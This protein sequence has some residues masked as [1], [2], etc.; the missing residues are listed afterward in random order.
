MCIRDRIK[1]DKI[2]QH[3]ITITANNASVKNSKFIGQYVQGDTEVV[4]AVVPNAGITGYTLSGNHFE[5]I[6]QPGYLE[7]AGTVTSNFVK[8]TRGWVVC[9]NHNLSL[10]HI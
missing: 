3:L 5:N 8:N 2:N 9:V 10:I 1:T 6:R 7:G 4:R